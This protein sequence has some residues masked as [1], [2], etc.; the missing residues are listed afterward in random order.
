ML[1]VSPWKREMAAL[2]A[3]IL[4]AAC[5]TPPSGS[6]PALGHN[7]GKMLELANSSMQAGVRQSTLSRL[8]S[9]HL[10]QLALD[11]ALDDSQS[12]VRVLRKRLEHHQGRQH[13][14][15]LYVA[16]H[17]LD[18]PAV[19]GVRLRLTLTAESV[20]EPLL[21][22]TLC[23]QALLS[24]I[25]WQVSACLRSAV[26]VLAAKVLEHLSPQ[27][28]VASPA[29]ITQLPGGL[30]DGRMVLHGH[31][32]LQHRQRSAVLAPEVLHAG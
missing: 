25:R 18:L 4:V 29:G 11:V 10:G 8:A 19:T 22:Q 28:C 9:A 30:N 26:P 5:I 6:E 32:L 23:C 31:M 21:A 2:S 14:S 16:Q 12:Q 24:Q 27:L 15:V 3:S 7:L 13:V 17:L 20:D 1:A